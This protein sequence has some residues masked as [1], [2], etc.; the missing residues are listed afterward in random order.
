MKTL[1]VHGPDAKAGKELSREMRALLVNA[2]VLQTKEDPDIGR[3]VVMPD[4]MFYDLRRIEDMYPGIVEVHGGAKEVKTKK[5]VP[6]GFTVG[7]GPGGRWFVKRGKEIITG[8]F[9]TEDEAKA[10]LEKQPA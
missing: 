1:V 2:T 7:K 6:A 5:V 3:V 10:A 8:P 4:V 9:A